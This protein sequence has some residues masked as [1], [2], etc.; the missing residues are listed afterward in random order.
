MKRICAIVLIL[1]FACLFC[2][3]TK[4]G[5]NDSDSADTTIPVTSPDGFEDVTAPPEDT[6][7][8]DTKAP[9]T[10]K[11][12]IEDTT[13]NTETA[14]DKISSAEEAI[15]CARAYKGEVDSET[16]YKY[17][18]SYDGTVVENGISLFRI[19]VSWYIEEEDRYSKCGYILVSPDG[20]C[21]EFDW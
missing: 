2:S 19:R 13:A 16:G 20:E 4:G 5:G 9:D 14:G 6:K 11:D 15:D 21:T 17:A 8:T 18:Y 3:C 10:E 1:T 12:E 7:N